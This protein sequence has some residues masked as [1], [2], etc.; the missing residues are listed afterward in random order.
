MVKVTHCDPMDC[1]PLSM[2][3]C[4]QEY[5]SGLPCPSPGD[6]LNPGIKP[7]SPALQ[8]NSLPSVPPGNLKISVR[9]TEIFIPNDPKRYSQPKWL[10]FTCPGQPRM[11]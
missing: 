11:E 9:G 6:L 10:S 2:E 8:V 7:R 1:S 5:C 3:F 4:M